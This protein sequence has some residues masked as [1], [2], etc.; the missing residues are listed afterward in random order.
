MFGFNN[1]GTIAFSIPFPVESFDRATGRLSMAGL[2]CPRNQERYS[3]PPQDF[4][5]Q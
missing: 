3:P 2:I 5:G 1:A 4:F